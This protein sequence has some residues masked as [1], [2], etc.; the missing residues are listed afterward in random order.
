MY[1]ISHDLLLILFRLVP[2]LLNKMV[3]SEMDMA[4]LDQDDDDEVPDTEKD[5]K[6]YFPTTKTRSGTLQIQTPS[7]NDT[8]S[9]TNSTTTT[10]NTTFTTLTPNTLNNSNNN[11]SNSSSSSSNNNSNNNNRSRDAEDDDYDDDDGDSNDEVSEWNIRKCSAAGLDTLS[12]VFQEDILPILLP[13]IQERLNFKDD[14]KVRESAIL[15]LGAIAEGCYYGMKSHLIQLVPYLITILADPQ[16]SHLSIY[17][18]I[19]RQSIVLFGRTD[20]IYPVA[21]QY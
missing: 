21:I 7:T 17:P 12:T 18:S 20:N 14:W 13:L 11:S 10:N 19:H 2:L 5:I 3:Y 9:T 1:P 4:L 15:A 16:V 8:N 6:P